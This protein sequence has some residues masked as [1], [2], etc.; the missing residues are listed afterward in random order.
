MCFLPLSHFQHMQNK[1]K[2]NH[3]LSTRDSYVKQAQRDTKQWHQ[4]AT[5]T[6]EGS[7]E[8]VLPEGTITN[9]HVNQ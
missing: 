5:D 3:H 9:K 2:S 8:I 1:W 4:F 6:I 7:R